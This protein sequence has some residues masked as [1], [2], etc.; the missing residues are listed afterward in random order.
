MSET[1][2]IASTANPTP[3]VELV[4]AA[5]HARKLLEANMAPT[6]I[7]I[8]L[9]ALLLVWCVQSFRHHGM[10]KAGIRMMLL[11][12]GVFLLSMPSCVG[13]GVAMAAAGSLSQSWILFWYYWIAVGLTVVFT[14]FV[15]KSAGSR[16]DE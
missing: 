12:V 15:F 1:A 6:L 16:V 5:A 13:C 8:G 10:H 3:W 9:T 14:G 7:L 4:P 2:I 11:G